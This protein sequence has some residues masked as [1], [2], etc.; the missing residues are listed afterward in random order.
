MRLCPSPSVYG[1]REGKPADVQWGAAEAQP[2]DRLSLGEEPV[3]DAALV[4]DLDRS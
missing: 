3:G 4:E 1:C 2:L